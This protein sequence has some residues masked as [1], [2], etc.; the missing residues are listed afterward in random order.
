M[1]RNVT[2]SVSALLSSASLLAFA[3][4]ASAQEE[5]PAIE[6]ELETREVIVV[7]G[8]NIPDEKRDTSEISAIVDSSDFSVTGDGDAAAALLRVTGLS[9]QR[10]RFVVVR[11][12]NERYSSATLNGSP[13][14]SPEPLRRVAPLDLFPTNILESVLVQKT[15]SPE[16]SLEFGGGIIDLRTLALPNEGFMNLQ[17]SAGVNTEVMGQDALLH[18]GGS[19]DWTGWDDGTRNLTPGLDEFFKNGAD[20]PTDAAARIDNARSL[21]NASLWVVQEGPASPDNAYEFNVGQRYDLESGVSVG[22]TGSLAYDN[23]W[24][25][26]AGVKND[27]AGAGLQSE[28]SRER[29]INE[30]ESSALG[31]IGFDFFDEH[32]VKLTAL[33]VRSTEKATER[34]FFVSSPSF[35]GA[36][37][38]STEWFE[39][40]A[41]MTQ[42]TGS[43]NFPSLGDL[44]MTWRA[45]YSEALR[46]APFSTEATYRNFGDDPTSTIVSQDDLRVR[47]Q[48]LDDDAA[49]L[50]VDFLLPVT[51]GPLD[52][53]VK[54]GW[55]YRE[56]NRDTIERTYFF[57]GNPSLAAG[58][59]VDLL[60]ANAG[61]AIAP[62][63]TG[64]F[65]E[66]FEGA[67]E[68]DAYYISGDFQIGP[69]VRASIGGR[70]EDAI[71]TSNAFTRDGG[72]DGVI[73]QAI[74]SQYFLP[75]AT[76]TW[77]PLDDQ[78]VRFGF[79][80]TIIRPQF[81]E[82]AP[83]V[84][85]NSLNDLLSQ[86]NSR[87]VNS[88]VTNYDLRY[89]W[90]FS[91]NQFFTAG[92]FYKEIEDPIIEIDGTVGDDLL[93]KFT[94]AP[95]A[96]LQGFE[97]EFEKAF[98]FS[99]RFDWGWLA[100]KDIIFNTNY[101]Y[102]DSEVDNNGTI[103]RFDG[104]AVGFSE[105]DADRVI[106]DGAQ[107][108]GQSE[109]LLN[110]QFGYDDF[111]ARSTARLLLN[112]ADERV[113]YYKAEGRQDTIEQ[114][115]VSLD[116][117]YSRAFDLFERELEVAFSAR[118]L[119]DDG[120]RSFRDTVNGEED[121]ISYDLGQSFSVSLTGRF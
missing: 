38:D 57:S 37:R 68:S 28:S 6:P 79:S 113:L 42:A 29:S 43:H 90:Y 44:E 45:S 19:E 78:Q 10:G 70:Y 87:L 112:F 60:I 62:L 46:D 64:D 110:I 21:A 5:P 63:S 96:T 69:Y 91:R 30:V 84:F 73:E 31:S 93:T 9:L 107:L 66:A 18:D 54:A 58:Q 59:R 72:D 40:Q 111:E 71:Q 120:Y 24:T 47:F 74:S 121:V 106:E 41:W 81:R 92:L 20:Y 116:F 32:Q 33:G 104:A 55:T 102:L 12:L 56:S 11:G 109:H 118:N 36:L 35:D 94:N 85:V 61:L 119:L 15:Y 52:V 48:T 105:F 86:G 27:P 39:R 22:V 75:A 89:E 23:S 80:Q 2:L 115:P 26:R 17:V 77:N 34:R 95:A 4:A 49:D 117:R 53:L 82:T 16:Y 99:E 108:P 98:D 51:A 50:G 114:P 83:Q 7:R 3:S 103:V 14:P 65:P 25:R 67:L 97:L 1:F 88:E 101:T 13:L 100:T 76:L 8:V